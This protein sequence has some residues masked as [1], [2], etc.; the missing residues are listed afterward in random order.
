[1][2]NDWLVIVLLL[3]WLEMIVEVVAD[4][5]VDVMTAV[6]VVDLDPDHHVVV[7]TDV[8]NDVEADSVVADAV[9]VADDHI[10]LHMHFWLKIYLQDAVG[11]I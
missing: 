11:L 9:V 8:M 3:N 6:V 5:V 1:M 2:V 10:E 7:M 4:A